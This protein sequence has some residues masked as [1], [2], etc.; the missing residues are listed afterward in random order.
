MLRITGQKSIKGL[1]DKKPDQRQLLT[2]CDEG[3]LNV[4][5]RYSKIS[6]MGALNFEV[7]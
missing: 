5:D 4:S 6:F 1:R 7:K 2:H 3:L